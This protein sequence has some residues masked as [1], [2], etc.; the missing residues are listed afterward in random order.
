M[1][2]QLSGFARIL[3]S[4][5]ESLI[6]EDPGKDQNSIKGTGTFFFYN[7]FNLNI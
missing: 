7:Y 5:F 4:I 3:Y 2:P 1:V 6:W